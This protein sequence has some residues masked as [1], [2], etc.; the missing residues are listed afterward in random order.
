[1]SLIQ[2][3]KSY[4]HETLGIKIETHPCR[5][6]L[7]FYLRDLYD[8]YEMQA[9][10]RTYI[11]MVPKENQEVT[12]ANARKHQQYVKEKASKSCIYVNHSLSSHNRKRLIQ[13]QVSFVIPGN[14]MY[15]PEIGVDLRERFQE[16]SQIIESL[17]WA[18]QF[19]IIY[20]LVKGK[21]GEFSPSQLADLLAYN[22]MTMTRVFNE[23]QNLD[24]FNIVKKG[25][26]RS[27]QYS[28]DVQELWEK[29]R[30]FLRSPVK[31]KIL[32]AEKQNSF[33]I[34]SGLSALSHY[35]MLNPPETP[36]FAIGNKEPIKDLEETIVHYPEEA[37]VEL[38][39]W[40]YDPLM[41]AENGVVD[42]FSL[43]L[44]LQN[45]IDERIELGLDQMMEKIL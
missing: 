19:V 34:V 40:H 25:K 41:F 16:Q 35:T 8:Y 30:P 27:F 36:V 17:S 24:I 39:I 9:I 2:N 11:L 6:K 3:L 12:P 10:D 5:I 31:R 7:P 4:L 26:G 32:L 33:E 37:S 15:L 18:S 23:F 43:Y 13:Q 38:E 44:S 20:L 28:G 22:K 45:E 14:Q 1:M 29:T 42:A 21:V